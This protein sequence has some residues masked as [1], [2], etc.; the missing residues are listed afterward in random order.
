MLRAMTYHRNSEIR[1]ASSRTTPG[2][3]DAANVAS[4]RQTSGS[5][6]DLSALRRDP[7][8]ERLCINTIRT[9][10]IDAVQQ[11]NSG[12]PGTPMALAPLMYT[13]WQHFMRYDPDD[14]FWPATTQRTSRCRTTIT[15]S[16]WSK[17]QKRAATFKFSPNA[18][19]GCCA[20][21]SARMSRRD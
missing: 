18:A 8:L 7:A 11:A 15:L 10:S 1:T 9:L 14:P 3:R 13:L 5:P 16:A 17:Q 12:H 21:I 4:L 20:C 19:V 2:A 6:R